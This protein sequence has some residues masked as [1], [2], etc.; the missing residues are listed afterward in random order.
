MTGTKNCRDI[1]YDMALA[2]H[3][4]Y[5]F[6]EADKYITLYTSKRHTPEAKTNADALKRNIYYAKQYYAKPTAAKI[7]NL[8]SNIN[9]A[10]DEYVPAILAD[11]S[12]LIYTYSGVKS[13]GGRQNAYLQKD[14]AGSYM[15][16]IY[17]S[18]RENDEFKPS[19][20]LDS[21]NTNA[22]DAAIS[23]SNDGK[24][25]F[26]YQDIG[27]SHGDIYESELV[28][29][30]YT[31]AKKLKGEINS[32]S[33]DGHCSLSPD[34]QT[35]FFSSERSG[36]YGGRDIYRASMSAD[37]TW[38]HIVNLGDS[39][40]TAYDDDAPFISGDGV[41]LFFSSKGRTSMGG[42]D[43]FRAIMNAKDSTFK[44]S[45]N[46]GYPINSPS[47]DIYFVLAAN[48][49]NAYYS[50]GKKDG[51]GMKDIYKVE[52]NFTGEKPSLYLVKGKVKDG[53]SGAEANIKVEISSK[54]NKLYK[55]LTSNSSTGAYLVTL[56]AGANY[57]LTYTYKDRPEQH[58]N[59]DAVDLAGYAEKIR[60]VNFEI[61]TP[62]PL[63]LT[64][65]KAIAIR[66]GDPNALAE[67]P[68]SNLTASAAKPDKETT[69]KKP[70]EQAEAKKPID[71]A[72]AK[73]K[74]EAL[75]KADTESRAKA[76][77]VARKQLE[78]AEAKKAKADEAAR[79]KEE[80][81]AKAKADAQARAEA[82]AKKTSRRSRS[83]KNRGRSGGFG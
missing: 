78:L 46:L 83:K 66:N 76:D 77:E 41:T 49:N 31:K 18:Y 50:S 6:D 4:T 48:G 10:D 12:A 64:D 20:S 74:E 57:H 29:D 32:Y 56:P 11:E 23:L 68:K 27:D 82:L 80:A 3:Y 43:I 36:G 44:R 7:S 54:N 9:S 21:L 60:D 16:D 47:D 72:A 79:I 19:F 33:W 73:A 52:T 5:K 15:E 35:L 1:Q 63:V 51:M 67:V 28:G 38:G 75:A 55:T 45:E 37:S 62:L 42:Y 81:V 53:T 70:T 30:H 71:E 2:C 22:P 13:I 14:P 65:K 59:I 8:G 58:L 39:V 17:M 34:G 25:L 24:I 61:P 40:N 69:D 26:I